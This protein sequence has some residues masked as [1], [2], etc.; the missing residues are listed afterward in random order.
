MRN[1]SSMDKYL[2][3]GTPVRF[4][5][6]LLSTFRHQ[7]ANS[8][9]ALKITLDVL[10]ENFDLFDD[11]KKKEYLERA[12]EVLGKQQAMVDAM[13]SYSRMNVNDQKPMNFMSFWEQFL[14]TLRQ[15]KQKVTS[16]QSLQKGP[17]EIM[18]SPTAIQMVLIE[19]L[20]NALDAV[21]GI[22]DPKIELSVAGDSERI[23]ICV[24]D[25]GCGIKPMDMGKIFVPLYTTKPQRKG[26]GLSI[27]FKLMAQMGGRLEI[28]RRDE[29]GT[30]ATIWLQRV[31]G[32]DHGQEAHQ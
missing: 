7:L 10:H 5:E 9:N 1:D 2:T 18:G 15:R 16:I 20:E 31:G 6:D 13:R 11:E 8:V 24:K 29:G 27:A 4:L 25:N 23:R 12:K 28:V 32:E 17:C 26:L 22:E 3:T 30:A 19:L 21:E 14:V